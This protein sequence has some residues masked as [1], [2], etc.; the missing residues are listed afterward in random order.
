VIT[1]V[2]MT[3]YLLFI[4]TVALS[5]PSYATCIQDDHLYREYRHE[6]RREET[7]N[8]Y[9]IVRGEV[10]TEH[11]QRYW[12]ITGQPLSGVPALQ[13]KTLDASHSNSNY[14]HVPQQHTQLPNLPTSQ[15]SDGEAYFQR[16]EGTLSANTANSRD[17]ERAFSISASEK[18][19]IDQLKLYISNSDTYSNW[20]RSATD[21]E[22]LRFVRARKGDINA[23]WQMMWDHSIWRQSSLGPESFS[24]A[25]HCTFERSLLNQEL[26]WSGK[27]Y[28]GSPVLYFKSG[29]H[30][31]GATDA[32]FYTR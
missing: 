13:Y 24:Q 4:L 2:I 32:Q 10:S 7:D 19:I 15:M 21:S 8:S 31:T 22:L 23:A 25:D 14:N 6:Q 17:V 20:L 26:F 9:A 3:H 27:A 30:Q 16:P 1:S 5:V 28:D 11:L 18:L 29:M 12:G